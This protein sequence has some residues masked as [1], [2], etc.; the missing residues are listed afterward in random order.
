MKTLKKSLSLFM[1]VLMLLSCWV[2]VAPQKAE[3]GAP[4]NYDV[5]IKGTVNNAVDNESYVYI[6]GQQFEFTDAKSDGDLSQTFT[7][8]KWPGSIRF[9]FTTNTMTQH[10]VD[11]K[12]IT[13]NGVTIF[14]DNYGIEKGSFGDGKSD[15]TFSHDGSIGSWDFAAKGVWT[16][17][18]ITT[19]TGKPTATENTI[20]LDR[21]DAT[22]QDKKVFSNNI[23]LA[24]YDQYGVKYAGTVEMGLKTLNN[25]DADLDYSFTKEDKGLWYENGNVYYNRDM[26]KLMPV[27][28]GT[29][30]YLFYHYE[31]GTLGTKNE[32]LSTITFNYPTYTVNVHPDGSVDGLVSVMDM[33]DGT[34]LIGKWTDTGVYQE[35]ADAWPTGVARKDGYIFKGF[36]TKPQ[37]TS[38]DAA[39]NAFEADFATP[40]SSAD[41]V[42][43]Y[44]GKNASDDGYTPYVEN[45]GKTYY[46]AGER[47]DA[48]KHKEV[49]GDANFYG[50]WNAEDV[51][52][53]FYDVDGTYLGTKT[54]KV[55]K[56]EAK[57]W[58]PDPKDGYVSGAYEYQGFSGTWRDITGA[59]LEEGAYTYKSDMKSLSLTPVYTTKT[60]TEKYAVKFIHPL[61]GGLIDANMSNSVGSSNYAYRH[62]LQG[63]NIP[64]A[65]VPATIAQN[66]DYA[67]EFT[68]WSSQEPAS[69]NY[70]IISKEDASFEENSDWVVREDITYYAVFRST[71]KEY[72]VSYSYIDSTGAEKTDIEYVPYGSIIATP[73]NVNRTYAFG[74]L[75]YNLE[76]WTYA[77]ADGSLAELNVDN[78]IILND[79]N[80]LLTSAN[81]KGEVPESPIQFTANYDDGTAMPYTITFKYKSEDG[82]DKTITAEV[83]HG[84]KIDADTVALLDAVPAQYDDGAALYTFANK[85]TV[86]EGTADE[87]NYETTALT[88][89]APVSHVTF[90]A[91]YGEG[92]PFY[93][94][95]YIDGDKTFSERILK[96]E[97]V[98]AWMV[99]SKDAEGNVTTKEYVPTKANSDE[100]KY[101]FAGWFDAVQTDKNYEVTNGTQYTTASTVEGDLVLYPQFTFEPFK[102]PVKFVNWDGSVIAEGEFEAGASFKDIYDLAQSTA[103][104][105]ADETY[106]YAFIG[107]DHKVPDNFLC[108]GK[109]MVYTAQYRPIYITY[110]ARWYKDEASMKNADTELE[111]VGS[112]GLLAITSHTY[113]A[114]VYAPSVKLDIENGKV[115]DGWYYMDG[116]VETKYQRGMAIT[117]SMSFYAKIKDAP[118]DTGYVITT[119]VN[120]ETTDYRIESGDTADVIGRPI[121]GYVDETTHNEFVGWY[122]TE[123]CTEGTE[124]SLDTVV[125][126]N[127]KVYAKFTVSAHDKDQKKLISAPTYY[128]EGSEEVWCA[129]NEDA[130]KETKSIA[131]LQD[132]IAPT[133]TIYLGGQSWSSTGAPAYE[134][135]ND[136]ISIFVNGNADIIITAN[137]KGNVSP[138]NPSGLGKGIKVIRAFAFP[139]G[140]VLTADAYGA[141]QQ[142]A[143]DVYTDTTETLTNSANYVVKLGDF[144][145][146]VVDGEGNLIP[147]TEGNVQYTALKDGESYILYYYV[148]DKA[149][150]DNGAPANGNQLNRKV[151][152]AKFTYDIKAPVFTIDGDSNAATAGASTVTYCGEAV[153]KGIEN[154]ATLTINGENVALTT[155]SADGTSNHTIEE[156]GNYIIKVTDK[157]GNSTSKKIRVTSGHDEVTSSKPVTCESDGY[158]KV[159]CAVCAKVIKNDVITSEGHKYGEVQTVEATCTKDGYTYKTC[160]VCGDV[161][162]LTETTKLNHVGQGTY[163]KETKDA[164]CSVKGEIT[165]Y[166]Q[167]CNAVLDT[168]ETDYDTTELG[169][170]YGAKKTL[171]A[172]CDTDGEVYRQCKYCYDK[173]TESTLPKLEHKNTGTYTVITVPAT[174]YSEGV[175]KTYCKACDIQMGEDAVVAKIAHTLKL[176]K[177]EGAANDDVANYE[178]G[179]MRYECQIAGCGYKGEKTA[180]KVTATYSITFVGMGADGTDLVITKTEGET[181]AAAD[182][183]AKDDKGNVVL[184]TKK[185][186]EYKNYT[187]AGW[188]GSDNKTINLPITVTKNDTYAPAYTETKRTYTHT[189]KVDA[190]DQDSFAVLIGTYEDTNK[191]PTAIPTKPATATARYEFKCW[192]TSAGVEVTDFTMT[193]D[194]TFV[195][196]FNEIETKYN[197]V[198]YNENNDLIWY[199][200]VNTTDDVKYANT[201]KDGNLIV[202]TKD[203][204]ADSHYKFAGWVYNEVTYVIDSVIAS[205]L[206]D[207][208]RIFASYTAEDHDY[209]V[210]ADETKTWAATCTKEGQTTEKC[211]VCGVEKVTTLPMIAH[212]YEVQADDSKK[213]TMCGDVVE[214]EVKEV[215]LT[216]EHGTATVTTVKVAEGKTYTITAADK[217]ATAEY[218]YTFE[219]WVDEDDNTVS[220]DA[221]LTVTATDANATYKAV[222]TAAKRT[223]KVIYVNWDYT[224]LQSFTTEFEYGSA[225]P[226]YT[227]AEPTRKRDHDNH[228]TFNGWSEDL[229]GTVKC[230]MMIVARYTGEK[231]NLDK[232]VTTPATCT[233]PETTYKVC[234]GENCDYKSVVG[235]TGDTLPHTVKEGT[236]TE[237]PAGF[238]KPGS[239]SF[240]CAT[241]DQTITE[242]IPA[243]AADEIT[244]IIYDN[245]GKLATNGTAHVTIYEIVDGTEVFFEGPRDTDGNGSVKFTVAR[246]KKWKAAITGDGIEGGY[247]GEVKAGTNVFGEAAEDNAKPE[248]PSCS[249]SCHKNTFWGIIYRFFQK[250]VMWLTG[251]PKCCGDPDPR[252]W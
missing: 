215:T 165:T 210:V 139:A 46:D 117:G 246:G 27:K 218:S 166:C 110:K 243:I 164:T 248:E 206:T 53:K 189:F 9:Y 232:E 16:A 102:F 45:G 106:Q 77:T 67:Y 17:P 108:E 91:V 216:F 88:S 116:T 65:S 6:G 145:V 151:R 188:K 121:D 211:S 209:K 76:S 89:F 205:K 39:Y 112:D 13:I 252:I 163:T 221:K 157:A 183:L 197:A 105:D 95:T 19:I 26:Q 224:I 130:T 242:T 63:T 18:K 98:P 140:T 220:T 176:V 143:I 24:F 159:T 61:T 234:S 1:A 170:S 40:V 247:G 100:G 137:D 250:L 138:Y 56:T 99:E 173:K 50:W 128:A 48:N 123:A 122:T 25:P 134:T 57:D 202:P 177:Y 73:D 141:A 199:T 54:T 136:D 240:V 154:G 80:V 185:S 2:W 60:Y 68:G 97:N 239:K 236:Y 5:T 182:V 72:V 36:W 207:N 233:T 79:S 81:L 3:A 118:T 201:D 90:E 178:N 160:S 15:V 85:W 155:S 47:W 245:S 30:Y 172:T 38:G 200:S 126:E 124:F 114:A 203:A 78:N 119:V 133:G 186:D 92:V 64:T 103:A 196:K 158:T 229:T 58:Y 12:T 180:I 20:T 22:L 32:L 109:E 71:V 52:V 249:C 217:D 43:V 237:E 83:N 150:T 94:V 184:P 162:V 4:T 49:L 113:N 44:G 21:L 28:S 169:H 226:A 225:I 132:T 152:T 181:I 82:I 190:A 231:H 59:L 175:Q 42:S 167:A 86:T 198:F 70:H 107:W 87:T 168:D 69:G 147:D 238:N 148:N 212:N 223:Y 156:A 115:F 142:V 33:N 93:T 219:K 127:T 75:G 104:K 135:D 228:Y 174:C 23:S 131:K 144:S 213:C 37:P 34:T 193:E 14:N 227:N 194:A 179:Y 125:T 187:F 251:N 74:G 55:G 161:D 29:E 51:T 230:D 214:A 35:R 84:K 235:S 10:D 7:V 195:A 222:Y 11:I 101:N 62:V 204:D 192:T 129:C 153:I 241:C 120:G 8:D 96:G 171:K 41:F 191:K 244:I 149:T 208:I 111:S 66:P 146:P 31:D